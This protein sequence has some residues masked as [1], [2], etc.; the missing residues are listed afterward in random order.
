MP[1]TYV[2]SEEGIVLDE[3]EQGDLEGGEEQEQL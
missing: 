1:D 3:R 2:E